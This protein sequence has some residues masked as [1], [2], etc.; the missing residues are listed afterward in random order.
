MQPRAALTCGR[1]QAR[2]EQTWPAL[3]T[4]VTLGARDPPTKEPPQGAGSF[5]CSN[6]EAG[7]GKLRASVAPPTGRI[8][9]GDC[10]SPTVLRWKV[11]AG[12]NCRPESSVRA[13]D[14]SEVCQP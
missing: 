5:S 7:P 3:E 1:H 14:P 9:Y 13:P 6:S 2:A 10:I 8:A 4:P 11:W 12:G